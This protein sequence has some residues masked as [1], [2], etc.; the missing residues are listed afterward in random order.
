M[1][2]KNWDSEL[3]Q[4]K[5][6][7]AISGFSQLDILNYFYSK[8]YRGCAEGVECELRE[9]RRAKGSNDLTVDDLFCFDQEHFLGV[10]AVEYCIAAAEIGK[11]SRV[12]DIGSGLGGPA[13]YLAHRTGCL[14]TG[15][16]VQPNRYE[17]SARLSTMVGLENRVRFVCEDF[18]LLKPTNES[19]THVIS[20]LSILHMPEKHEVLSTVGQYLVEGGKLYLEDYYKPRQ[21]NADE[22]EALTQIIS[23]PNLLGQD[24]YA[25]ALEEGGVVVEQ[26]W[27][28]T[29]AWKQDVVQRYL[30]FVRQKERHLRVYGLDGAKRMEFLFRDVMELFRKGVIGGFRILGRK[31]G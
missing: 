22:Q 10:E 28:M 9:L 30:E 2:L 23:C 11:E 20:H 12:L 13:R 1:N 7:T 3:V 18:A 29:E 5:K 16:E 14:V 19:F 24:G 26:I 31:F 21:L 25:K 6:Q 27:D 8:Y 4:G 15:I 17:L